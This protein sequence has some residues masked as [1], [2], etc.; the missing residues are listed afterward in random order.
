MLS[1]MLCFYCTEMIVSSRIGLCY[2]DDNFHIWILKAFALHKQDCLW[3]NGYMNSLYMI[4]KVVYTNKLLFK[5]KC[6]FF[7]HLLLKLADSS[8]V[9]PTWKMFLFFYIHALSLR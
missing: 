8:Q 9:M 1:I 6:V 2:A 5:M 7:K 3:G 4:C